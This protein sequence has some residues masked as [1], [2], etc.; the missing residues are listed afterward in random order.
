MAKCTMGE[1]AS[2]I[3]RKIAAPAID[4]ANLKSTKEGFV[5]NFTISCC[6]RREMDELE[7]VLGGTA[8]PLVNQSAGRF[9]SSR[10]FADC[11]STSH[12]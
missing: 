7:I 10:S 5:K 4:F 8:G 12:Q 1:S 9:F 11:D 3:L 2:R 6:N